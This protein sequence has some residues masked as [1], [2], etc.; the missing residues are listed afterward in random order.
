MIPNSLASLQAQFRALKPELLALLRLTPGEEF[1]ILPADHEEARNN[2]RYRYNATR[3]GN[4][5]GVVTE[6]ALTRTLQERGVE[7]QLPPPGIFWY[8]FKIDLLSCSLYL[9]VKT[10]CGGAQRTHTIGKSEVISWFHFLD[11]NELNDLIILSCEHISPS[12]GRFISPLSLRL[13]D[14]AN[15]IRQSKFDPDARYFHVADALL[16]S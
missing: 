6:I 9:D 5:P 7:L 14:E 15:L 12:V 3:K 2:P 13:I 16:L 1:S 10:W 11:A 8:D 4:L